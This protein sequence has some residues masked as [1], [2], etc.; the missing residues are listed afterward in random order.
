MNEHDLRKTIEA[1]LGDRIGRYHFPE[2]DSDRAVSVLPDPDLGYNYPP[3][4]TQIEGIEVQIIK[5]LIG[6]APLMGN[7]SMRPARWEVRLRAIDD[8]RKD[9]IELANLL[10][11]K[12]ASA[13]PCLVASP[14]HIP[15][16]LTRGIL[17]QIVIRLT[18]YLAE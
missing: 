16:D 7:R 4:N 18:V 9:L 8:S 3:K 13:L 12:L 2:G 10:T 15:A 11:P 17:E 5:P 6:I 1:T 14:G